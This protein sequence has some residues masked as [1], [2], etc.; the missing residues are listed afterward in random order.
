MA[1][2]GY[3]KTSADISPGAF[4]AAVREINERRFAGLLKLTGERHH[5]CV[6][7]E[8][9]DVLRQLWLEDERSIEVRHAAGGGDLGWWIDFVYEDEL[10]SRFKG[11]ISD[12]GV[13]G[14]WGPDANLYPTLA[15]FLAKHKGNGKFFNKLA[16]GLINR[17]ALAGYRRALPRP[18]RPLLGDFRGK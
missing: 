13:P 11:R 5:W 15:D 12:D 10:A 4:D 3:V 2:H 14:E 1:N 9:A 17:L 6:E 8:E 18:W 16:N 7:V